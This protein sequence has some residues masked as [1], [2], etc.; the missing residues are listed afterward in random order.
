[1]IR[2]TI[3]GK[4]VLKR[5]QS[6]CITL[7]HETHWGDIL[8][9]LFFVLLAT[10]LWYGH[11]LQS[12]RNATIPV[13]VSYTGIPENVGIEKKHLPDTLLVDVRDAGYRLHA[14]RSE[15]PQLTIDLSAQIRDDKGTIRVSSDVLRRSI[16]DILQG[17]SKLQ[18]VTPE[19]I[20]CNYYRQNECLLPVEWDGTLQPATEYYLVGEPKLSP[21]YV[22]V[23]G[24]KDVLDTIRMIHSE[25]VALGEL[26]DTT[27]ARIALQ[28]PKGVRVGKDS[29]S[30]TVVT[31]RFTE[32]AFVVPIVVQNVPEGVFVRLFPQE[33]E[34]TVQVG[35]SRFADVNADDVVAQC[36]YPADSAE[37]LG[38]EVK[39]TNP[40][41]LSARAYPNEV[42]FIVER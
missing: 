26:K 24:R 8:T 7:M 18:S 28:V 42:E 2:Y 3:M 13:I 23:Y 40:Y 9:F 25:L 29:V 4:E 10:A 20:V 19:Q 30:L 39:Y 1:M 37:T 5:I 27:T 16:T 31:E 17:T 35:M 41:I 12:V 34:V 36:E 22:K 21:E 11:A 33:T 15:R 38:V 6:W 14:Y 32:K